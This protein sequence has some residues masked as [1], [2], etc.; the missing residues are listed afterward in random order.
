MGIERDRS[1]EEQLRRIRWLLER[2]VLPS[3]AKGVEYE[4]PY[5]DVTELNT[6]RVIKDSV[7]RETLKRIAEDAI[8][9][10]ETSVAVYEVNG[11]YA[12]GLFSSGWC[13]LMDSAS[14]GA[15]RH[16]RQ[17][18]GPVLRQMAVPRDMLERIGKAG[19]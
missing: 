8:D 7:S 11:D 1:S 3:A 16:G 10:L 5:G 6:C 4:P 9:L 2:S 17:P 14:R 13:R 18:G 12:F 15:L 19:H